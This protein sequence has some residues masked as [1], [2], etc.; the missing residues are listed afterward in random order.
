MIKKLPGLSRP[1]TLTVILLAGSLSELP[2]QQVYSIEDCIE[3]ALKSNKDIEA[4]RHMQLRYEYERDA[5]RSNYFPS[6]ELTATDMFST[7]DGSFSYDLVSPAAQAIAVS[8]RER[9]PLFIGPTTQQR[10]STGLA[11]RFAHM[12]PNIDYKIGNVIVANLNMTQPIY[13]G[14]K[15]SAGYR[16]GSYGAQMAELSQELT[17]EETIV[18]VH[19]AYLLLVKAKDLL[20]VAQQ[21]DSLLVQLMSDVKSA[22]SHGMTKI[23]DQLKVQVKKNEAEL[24]VIQAEN[25]IRL[26]RMNLCQVIGLPLNSE[27]EVSDLSDSETEIVIGGE[28]VARQRTESRLLELKTSIAQQQ[29]KLVRSGMLPQVGV[30]ANASLIDGIEIMGDKL[31]DRKPVFTVGV[32]VKVPLFH[33]GENKKKVRAAKEELAQSR[34]EQESLNEKMSLELQKLTNEVDE[35]Q[36]ELDMRIRSLEQCDENLRMSRKSYSVGY[37]PISDLLEAQLLWQQAYAELAEARYQ[38]NLKT[39]KWLKAAGQLSY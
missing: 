10:I 23:N 16:M 37:E 22:V 18:A 13:M 36:L 39:V 8:L 34:L 9:L 24:R 14:G 21:Y 7:F 38:K 33:A 17:K 1:I 20:A 2:A 26:A 32:S 15:I 29:V 11:K 19:E 4:S 28:N 3:M 27:F 35:S 30:T 25:G 31:L 6:L 12:N 5:V